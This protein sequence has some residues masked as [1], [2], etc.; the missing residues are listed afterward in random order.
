[1]E[2]GFRM[3]A[4]IE[5]RL[6]SVGCIISPLAGCS[7]V[8]NRVSG[9]GDEGEMTGIEG[10]L[11]GSAPAPMRERQ[12]GRY[13]RSGRADFPGSLARKSLFRD[14]ARRIKQ[15]IKLT[16]FLARCLHSCGT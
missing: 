3:G 9:A 16:C 12:G 8:M 5:P 6:P 10:Y 11:D 7:N 15:K 4:G 1:M 13:R 14:S 2:R